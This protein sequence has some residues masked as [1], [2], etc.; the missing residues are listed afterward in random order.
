[1][2]E[3]DNDKPRIMPDRGSKPAKDTGRWAAFNTTLGQYVA[4]VH[5][6][7]DKAAKAAK[8]AGVTAFTVVEV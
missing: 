6:S 1:M 4:G 7:K 5:D 3:Q 8:D 2:A